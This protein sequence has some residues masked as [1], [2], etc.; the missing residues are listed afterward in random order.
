MQRQ[1]RA[2]VVVFQIPGHLSQEKDLTRAQGAVLIES[3]TH[4]SVISEVHGSLIKRV[5]QRFGVG[6]IDKVVDK[7]S[8]FEG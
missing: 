4:R 8:R 1:R 7:L 6:G 5:S 2:F 3:A